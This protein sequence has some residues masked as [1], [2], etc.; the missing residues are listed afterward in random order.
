MIPINLDFSDLAEEFSLSRKE[1]DGILDYTVK[2]TA[3][4]FASL[5]EREAGKLGSTR[6]LYMRSIVVSNPGEFLAAVELSNDL[7]NMIESGTG[8]FDMKPILLGGGKVKTGPR[9]KYVT[10]PFSIGTPGALKENFSTIMPASVYK[11]ARQQTTDIQ[12]VGGSRSKGLSK[13]DLPAEYREPITKEVFNP[14]SQNF[15][16]YTHKSSIY[17]GIIKQRS[18]VTNQN[19]YVG[20]RRVSLNSDPLSWI[21]PG[22]TARNFAEKALDKLD[23]PRTVS[24]AIDNFLIEKGYVSE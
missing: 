15:E 4:K 24:D 9:G 22:F 1:I 20:F 8:P 14:K 6:N 12:V 5:W 21:H 11:V 19:S 18:N 2:E 23:L 13:N 17:E 16:K 10:V 7:P 3:A